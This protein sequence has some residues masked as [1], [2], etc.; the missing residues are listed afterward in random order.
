MIL[1]ING[2]HLLDQHNIRINHILNKLSLRFINLVFLDN[3]S[4]QIIILM[5]FERNS[6]HKIITFDDTIKLH[7]RG[8]DVPPVTWK[9][10]KLLLRKY[11]ELIK[12]DKMTVVI[13]RLPHWRINILWYIGCILVFNIN[14]INLTNAYGKALQERRIYWSMP[15]YFF[16]WNNIVRYHE[17]GIGAIKKI[18]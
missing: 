12:W 14:K 3:W 15:W 6:T 18:H 9:C 16:K 1:E 10:S 13:S 5:Y 7:W 17:W 2:R 8:N 4:T 11:H